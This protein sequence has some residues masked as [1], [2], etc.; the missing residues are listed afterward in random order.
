MVSPLPEAKNVHPSLVLYLFL[1]FARQMKWLVD[2]GY[3][4]AEVIRLVRD[5]LST[6]SPAA[7]YE[8]HVPRRGAASEPEAGV[9]LHA[10]HASWLNMAEIEFSALER[11]W[12]GRRLPDPEALARECAAWED[13][14]NR[15]GATV[16][17]RFTTT[18]ARTKLH[19][20]Y[21]S[22]SR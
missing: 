21:P 4:E 20:L 2:L 17:W 13:A 22:D 5:N 7:F 16:E 11:Q 18:D 1:D 10:R 3:P 15:A 19:L 12:L 14:S 9:P 6:H 8:A